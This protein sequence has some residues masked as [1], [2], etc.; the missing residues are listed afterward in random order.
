MTNKILFIDDEKNV[1][2]AIRRQLRKDFDVVTAV[3]G[4][5]AI[6]AVSENGPFAVAVCDM[7][8]PGMDGV[9]TLSE[10]GK[11]SPDTV[12]MMLTGNADQETAVEAINK[13]QIF[14]FLNKP[15]P[16]E[17]LRLAIKD[18]L[19]QYELVTAERTLLQHTL[20]GSVKVLM[21]VLSLVDASAFGQATRIRDWSRSVA[22]KL[23]LKNAW[24]LDMAATLSPLGLVAVPPDIL[25]KQRS[26]ASLTSTEQ[27]VYDA[28][29]GT[30]RRLIAN[31]PRL[32]GVADMVYYQNKAFSGDGYPFDEDISGKDIPYGA[33]ILKVLTDL[34]SFSKNSDPAADDVLKLQEQANQ[35]DPKILE[36]VVEL[37]G[38]DSGAIERRGGVKKEVKVSLLLAGD[39]L[40]SDVHL[41]NGNLLL[42]AGNTVTDAH[43]ERM[44]SLSELTGIVEPI[45]IERASPA[46]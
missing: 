36:A 34:S 44:R 33:R 40:L 26:G 15:C 9:T 11:K 4:E 13:G 3:G 23:E 8:M 17:I 46:A 45:K 39:R 35:Y 1:L 37:W 25:E 22:K 42:A 41:K 38:S 14:R 12:R 43:I 16:E 10:I 20:A 31:I 30:G 19:R 24:D 28:S 6:S 18:A 27:D 7:R 29:P 21:D 2:T 5:E 32:S